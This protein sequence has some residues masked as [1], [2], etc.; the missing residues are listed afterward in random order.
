MKQPRYEE[1]RDAMIAQDK[2]RAKIEKQLV[3]SDKFH[4]KW[5]KY[6]NTRQMAHKATR[7]TK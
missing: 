1:K 2:R 5:R 4:G 7:E 3:E 6:L